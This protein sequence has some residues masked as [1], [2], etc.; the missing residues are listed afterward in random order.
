MASTN[1]KSSE[2]T[3]T[4]AS[5][6][7]STKKTTVKKSNKTSSSKT[8]TKNSTSK[9]SSSKA[10]STVEKET[11]SLLSEAIADKAGL[12][13]KDV[14]K[15]LTKVNK[16]PLAG[17]I[18]VGACFLLGLAGGYVGIRLVQRNDQ[19]SLKN[20]NSWTITVGETY[21]YNDI[22]NNVICISYGR[23]VINTVSVDKANT[24]LDTTTVGEYKVTYVSSDV[25]Y[26]KISLVQTVYVIVAEDSY[27]D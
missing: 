11:K 16:L 18:A 8:S 22:E 27:S 15:A 3:K 12:E 25:K 4:S 24:T 1:S 9:K 20:G 10:S 19:F 17:K 13:K 5:S 7:T 6:K 2:D 23:N 14:S 26:T 21:D